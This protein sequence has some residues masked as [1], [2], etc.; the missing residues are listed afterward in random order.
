MWHSR[1]FHFLYFFFSTVRECGWV[2]DFL[3]GGWFLMLLADLII[4]SSFFISVLM[5]LI[6][7][8][9]LVFQ[10]SVKNK[11]TFLSGVSHLCWF[12]INCG[13]VSLTVYRIFEEVPGEKAYAPACCYHV[14]LLKIL[15][16]FNIFSP[17]LRH[18]YALHEYCQGG[19][20]GKLLLRLSCC[21]VL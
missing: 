20:L 16:I 11:R 18:V 21:S 9:L 3:L 2:N 10:M 19:V 7:Q 12:S 8:R 4:S 14:T 17:S 6:S 13:G 1:L 15:R 5:V